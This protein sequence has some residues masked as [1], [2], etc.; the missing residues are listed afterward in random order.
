M[1]RLEAASLLFSAAASVAAVLG[2]AGS[3][4]EF[5]PADAALA[6]LVASILLGG[7]GLALALWRFSPA[8]APQMFA[9]YAAC[10]LAFTGGLAGF[11]SA[12]L[13]RVGTD[14]TS[15]NGVAVPILVYVLSGLGLLFGAVAYL[16]GSLLLPLRSFPR[17]R[18]PEISI[19]TTTTTFVDH[20]R[21]WSSY[22]ESPSG[23]R[24]VLTQFWYPSTLCHHD[25]D[26][27]REHHHAKTRL[28]RE[29]ELESDGCKRVPYGS[30]AWVQ[31][32][33]RQASMPAGLFSHLALVR[34][35]A[36]G[37]AP[38]GVVEGERLPVFI[39]SHGVSVLLRFF[40]LSPV[41]SP[42]HRTSDLLFFSA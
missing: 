41:S 29:R 6:V 18:G 31:S 40:F 2:Q 8:R 5:L 4:A 37:D 35:R 42:A 1:R 17:P 28:A 14:E 9:L 32:M 33:A 13:A 19:G 38:V 27:H 3:S 15:T 36:H 7:L 24:T 21:P 22:P 12:L 30:A 23:P 11:V 16:V 26:H 39:F 20:T 25:A 34:C 10:T